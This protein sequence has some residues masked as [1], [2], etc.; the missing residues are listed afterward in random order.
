[1]NLVMVHSGP[2]KLAG[3]CT[4]LG[5][6]DGR[7]VGPSPNRCI[8]PYPRPANDLLE[9]PRVQGADLMAMARGGTSPSEDRRSAVVDFPDYRGPSFFL[10]A[11]G[12]L[13]AVKGDI[14]PVRPMQCRLSAC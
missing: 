1:M 10:G 2:G 7:S 8:V 3:K 6:R 9:G 14:M 5:R 11:G 4:G 12:F 13:R